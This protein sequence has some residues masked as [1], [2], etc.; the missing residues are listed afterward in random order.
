MTRFAT[1]R[2]GVQI[3]YRVV[4]DGPVDLVLCFG[5]ISAID[6]HDAID[7][8]RDFIDRLGSFARVIVFDRR[9]AGSS[10]RLAGGAV[11]PLEAGVEDVRAVLDAVGSEQAA[12]FGHH[13]GALVAAL[14]AAFHPARTRALVL[15]CPEPCGPAADWPWGWSAEEWETNISTIAS[16]WGTDEY[17]RTVIAWGAPSVALV[18]DRVEQIGRLMRLA[19]NA[20]TMAAM[21]RALRDTDIR[22]VL[23]A[24]R[25]PTLVLHRGSPTVYDED[26]SRWVAGQIGGARLAVLPGDDFLAW[27]DPAPICEEIEEHLLG[28]R[29]ATADDRV[30][31]TLLVT[32]IVGSTDRL[33]TV[34]DRAWVDLLARF[35][36]RVRQT[37]DRARGRVAVHTGDGIIATFDG[38]ARAVR[39]AA[40][41]GRLGREAGLDVRAGCHTGEVELATGGLRGI[42]VHVAARIAAG[43]A[44]GEVRTSAIVRDLTAGS[45]LEFVPCG[46]HELKGV[47]GSWPLYRAAG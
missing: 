31:T 44:A 28:T 18:A 27:I 40:A 46:E 7:E 43:A 16:S 21:Q 38:P 33:A 34:G 41:I 2:D 5:M 29:S 14:F 3:A 17:V 35:D 4:G 9:G 23:P 47:P 30:L 12:L 26:A 22:A 1:T 45:G 42:A 24:I 19:G 37:V 36:E 25:A 10:D 32:D 11:P 15:H 20:S 13:D 8:L 39:C 6:Y